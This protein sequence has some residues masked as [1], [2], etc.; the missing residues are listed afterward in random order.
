MWGE[1]NLPAPESVVVQRA[2]IRKGS[3]VRLRPRPGGD[4]MDAALAGRM[5]VVEGIDQSLEGTIHIAVTL[6]DDPGCDLGDARFPGHRF[7]FRA[8][9]VEPVESATPAAAPRILVAGIGNI[10]FGDDGFG[11]AVA[12][13]LAQ[14]RQR[15]GVTVRDFGIR[16]LDLAYTMQDDYDAVILIDAVPRGGAPGTLYVIEPDLDI[17]EDVVPD[18]H[19][20]DPV[21]VLRLA[22]S[23]GRVPPR[24]VVVGCEPQLLASAEPG[25]DAL[26]QLSPTVGAAVDEA[27]RQVD[28]LVAELIATPT[29]HAKQR[30]A[31]Q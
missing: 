3:R 13:R 11:V 31:D 30:R 23:L 21:K 17:E 8:D 10:F 26:V 12:Q 1:L 6:E 9:E 4:I 18:A 28:M 2:D 20:M 7:Y 15:P 24:T 25:A 29:F 22:R 14:R 16:G 19:G 27:M 5:A